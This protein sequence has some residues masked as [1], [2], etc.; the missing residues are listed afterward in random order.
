[1]GLQGHFPLFEK[2]WWQNLANKYREIPLSNQKKLQEIVEKIDKQRNLERKRT[3][4]FSL[5]E[6]ERK[7]FT[8]AFLKTLENRILD[9]DVLLH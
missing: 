3:V 8:C 5:S 1:M 6:N 9:S 4:F 7:L 2:D